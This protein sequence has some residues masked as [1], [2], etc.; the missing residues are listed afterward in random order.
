MAK[1]IV[2]R[3]TGDG[4]LVPT[5][6]VGHEYLQKMPVGKELGVT[7]VQAR[8]YLFH[9]KIICL[10]QYLYDVM[11]RVTA[12][13]DGRPEEQSFRTFR[14]EFIATAGHYDNVVTKRGLRIE[15]KSISY[16]E[17]SEELAEQIYSDCIDHALKTLG[18]TNREDL[19]SI[20]NEIL[21]FDG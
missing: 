3:K 16:A 2:M 17:C 13:I 6:A 15:A 7:I 4:S 12:V 8:N 11:P 1:D 14:H 10:L 19:D 21:R 18:D 9:Q 20:V 5:D